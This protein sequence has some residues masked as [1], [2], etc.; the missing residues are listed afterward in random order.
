MYL[1]GKFAPRMQPTGNENVP[2]NKNKAGGSH[3]DCRPQEIHS[4]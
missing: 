2:P 1:F 4:G 3:C